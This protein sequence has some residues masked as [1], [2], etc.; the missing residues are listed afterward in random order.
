MSWGGFVAD[1]NGSVRLSFDWCHDF[2][3]WRYEDGGDAWEAAC[4]AAEVLGADAVGDF[5]V[6]RWEGDEFAELLLGAA[7]EAF[8]VARS[9]SDDAVCAAAFRRGDLLESLADRVRVS[10]WS[11]ADDAQHAWDAF[12]EGVGECA[13]DWSAEFGPAFSRLHEVHAHLD[14]AHIAAE[15]LDDSDA[16]GER[17]TVVFSPGLAEFDCSGRRLGFELRTARTAEAREV[18]FRLMEDGS[19][20]SLEEL[21]TAAE[22]L[23]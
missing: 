5:P 23:V 9:S 10:E 13:A 20:L 4:E 1:E 16:L 17:V 19:E 22:A 2:S 21:V 14:A 8:Q 11:A 6:S 7:A 3:R 18:L 12:C 15:W